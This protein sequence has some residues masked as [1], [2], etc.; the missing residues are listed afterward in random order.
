MCSICICEGRP[1]LFGTSNLILYYITTLNFDLI[2][3]KST[4][5]TTAVDD[6]VLTTYIR[7]KGSTTKYLQYYSEITERYKACKVQ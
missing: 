7:L 1:A 4:F 5:K 3:K 6:A 2:R